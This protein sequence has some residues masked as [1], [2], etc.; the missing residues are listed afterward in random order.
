LL[1]L[2]LALKPEPEPE[3]ELSLRLRLEMRLEMELALALALALEPMLT[4]MSSKR[5]AS[6][7][8]CVQDVRAEAVAR[9]LP[10]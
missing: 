5:E 9:L 10:I 6:A 2:K 7:H 1:G 8:S 3:L 4:P